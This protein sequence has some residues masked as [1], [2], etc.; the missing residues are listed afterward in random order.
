MIV[1]RGGD[2]Y[3]AA[4]NV[5]L[6][7]GQSS[8]KLTDMRN[9]GPEPEVAKQHDGYWYYSMRDA[10]RIWRRRDEDT[11]RDFAATLIGDPVVQSF[12]AGKTE[13]GTPTGIW[14]SGP[15][16]ETYPST[17]HNDTVLGL[18]LDLTWNRR[19]NASR[20]DWLVVVNDRKLLLDF[21]KQAAEPIASVQERQ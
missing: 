10:I 12:L 14:A 9:P 20:N 4:S 11:V 5:R 16:S 18:G 3:C 19:P 1:Q 17:L 7:L 21:L 13:P 2:T 6:L 8:H 15:G